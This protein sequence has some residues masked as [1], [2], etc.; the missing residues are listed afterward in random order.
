MLE[1][2]GLVSCCKSYRLLGGLTVVPAV[3]DDTA[4]KIDLVDEL[5]IHKNGQA[6]NN[7]CTLFLILRPYCLQ[8][9]IRIG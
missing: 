4:Y 3:A 7:Y 9:I 5:V 1:R 2:I 6:R 8:R